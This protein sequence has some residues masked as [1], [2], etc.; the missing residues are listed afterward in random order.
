MSYRSKTR[1]FDFH[2]FS[3][4]NFLPVLV[5]VHVD[6]VLQFNPKRPIVFHCGGASMY[7]TCPFLLKVLITCCPPFA[8]TI[9]SVKAVAAVIF[10]ARVPINICAG[11]KSESS[12]S[13]VAALKI[14]GLFVSSVPTVKNVPRLVKVYSPSWT[15]A[16]RAWTGKAINAWYHVKYADAH[17]I[18]KLW[19]RLQI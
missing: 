19:A 10:W 6:V 18:R 9:H 5:A 3:S 8:S 2:L 14:V 12:S 4:P 11:F 13:S 1:L 15:A 16:V 17:G 7:N